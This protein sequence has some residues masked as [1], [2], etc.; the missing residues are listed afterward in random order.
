MRL[1]SSALL[2]AVAAPLLAFAQTNS[3]SGNGPNAFKIPP[4]GL[5]A[6]A[7]QTTNLQWTPT[8]DGSVTL[9]LRSGASNNLNEGAVI[10]CRS[11]ASSTRCERKKKC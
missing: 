2:A 10:A 11:S 1:S 8:T 6:S 3:T 5:T 7:G 9:I 4:S